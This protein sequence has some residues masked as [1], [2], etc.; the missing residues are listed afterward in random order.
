MASEPLHRI[1]VEEYLALERR[2]KTKKEYLK[3]EI[4]ATLPSFAEYRL[5]APD[6]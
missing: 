6:T 1:S 4:F 5:L 2:S 3:G